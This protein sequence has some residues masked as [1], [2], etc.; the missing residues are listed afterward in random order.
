MIDHLILF[1]VEKVQHVGVDVSY[2]VLN[3]SHN[4]PVIYGIQDVEDIVFFK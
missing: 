3:I 2:I 1:F 4:D